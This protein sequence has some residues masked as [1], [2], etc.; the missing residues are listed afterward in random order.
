[1]ANKASFGQAVQV[2]DLMRKAGWDEESADVQAFVAN[3]G[4]FRDLTAALKDGHVKPETVRMALE[5]KPVATPATPRSTYLV[6]VNYDIR[7]AKA[8]RACRFKGCVNPDIADEHFKAT[9]HGKARVEIYLEHLN[10]DASDQDVIA[11]LESKGLRSADLWELLALAKKY[12][13]LQME[14]PISALGS[15]WSLPGGSRF[16]PCLYRG[17][18]QRDLFLGY[19][20]SRWGAHCRFAAVRTE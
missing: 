18:G 20:E 11:H 3:W 19:L 9:R 5:S 17:D 10:R 4:L 1:M 2:L 15:V 6:P 12:P 16:V 13:N 7:V 14:F 8:I